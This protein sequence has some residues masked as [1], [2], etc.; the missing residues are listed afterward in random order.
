MREDQYL[1]L[2]ARVGDGLGV[3]DDGGREDDLADGRFIRAEGP[4]L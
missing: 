3:S 1:P 2:V 4:A